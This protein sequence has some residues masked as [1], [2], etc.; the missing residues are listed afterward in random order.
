MSR[1][2]TSTQ[3]SSAAAPP[4]M[5]REG[6]EQMLS[7][8]LSLYEQARYQEALSFLRP[9]NAGFPEDLPGIKVLASCYHRMGYKREAASL[10]RRALKVESEQ[11][12][13]LV[14]LGEILIAQLRYDEALDMLKKA[15]DL[16]PGYAN[17]NSQRARALVMQVI[18]NLEE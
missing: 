13:V 8:G 6:F 9:A 12:D 15:I 1:T 5:S 16:D 14:N 11:P 17:P 2:A 18:N 3:K 7:W 4:A 10:Y